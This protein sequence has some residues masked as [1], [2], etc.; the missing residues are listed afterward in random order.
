MRSRPRWATAHRRPQPFLAQFIL[1]KLLNHLTKNWYKS[2]FLLI[3]QT[4]SARIQVE[5][6]SCK[7]GNK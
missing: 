7:G 1:G 3:F 5:D 6:L 2:D 4:V